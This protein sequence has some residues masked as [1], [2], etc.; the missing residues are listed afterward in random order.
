MVLAQ[1]LTGRP[2]DQS[3]RSRHKPTQNPTYLKQRSPKHTVEKKASL[4]NPAGK[5]GYPHAED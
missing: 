2:V 5:A 3:R 4:T 1:K